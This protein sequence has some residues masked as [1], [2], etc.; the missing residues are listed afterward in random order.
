MRRVPGLF[1]SAARDEK[2]GD[3]I[4]KVVNPGNGA[5]DAQ[6]QIRGA[7]PLAP[8]ASA[9]VLSSS[10]LNDENSLDAPTRV[11][12]VTTRVAGAGPEFRHTFRPYSLTVLRLAPATPRA[13]NALRI[14]N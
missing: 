11:A 2:S 13:P 9:S 12:P 8:T 3:V 7:P 14:S 10:S 4:L 1:A 6:L 5:V